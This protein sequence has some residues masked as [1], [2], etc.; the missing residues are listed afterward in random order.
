[1]W[2]IKINHMIIENITL[3]IVICFWETKDMLNG[4]SA[5]EL[6]NKSLVQDTDIEKIQNKSKNP[7]AEIDKTLLID[8]SNISNEAIKLYQRDLE[9]KK[10]AGL[11]MSD[12]ENTDYNNLVIEKVFQADDEQFNSKII[13]GIFENKS[14][15]KDLLG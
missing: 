12:P 8:E 13:D 15:I 14:F 2:P 10:F 3:K 6:A 7:Y 5:Q 4:I 1:M 11:A 9:I